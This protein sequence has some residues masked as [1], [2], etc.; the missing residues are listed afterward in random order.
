M[1]SE[2]LEFLLTPCLRFARQMG[3]LHEVIAIKARHARCRRAWAPHL[4]RKKSSF[5]WR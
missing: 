2:A 3:Y 4:E 5:E 1:L